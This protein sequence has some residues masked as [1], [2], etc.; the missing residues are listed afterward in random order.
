VIE[1]W[2]ASQRSARVV[3]QWM[4][5]RA[6]IGN[7]FASATPKALRHVFLEEA[8]FGDTPET[9]NDRPAAMWKHHGRDLVV[10]GEPPLRCRRQNG[11]FSV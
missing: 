3:H 7:L 1:F 4:V 11:T 5:R 6:P 8:F 10:R 9:S 2:F